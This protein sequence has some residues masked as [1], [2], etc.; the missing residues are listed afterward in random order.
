MITITNPKKFTIIIVIIVLVLSAGIFRYVWGS[1]VMLKAGDV[2]I[3]QGES[4]SQIWRALVSDGF[5][6]RTIPW[7]WYARSGSAQKIQAGK[8]H[9]E[10]GERI[11]DVVNRFVEGD[12]N[13]NE[14]SITFPEGFT[15]TQI[16]QRLEQ[17]GIGTANGFEQEAVVGN[18]SDKF[19]FLTGL[20]AKR[21]LEG[22]LFP[23]TYRI[24]KDDTSH[25]VIMKMLGN[26][27]KK[28]SQE[29][30][31]SAK[32]QHRTLDQE[33]TIASIIEKEVFH[34]E[35]LPTVAGIFWKR[36]DESLGLYADSTI[37]YAL[38]KGDELTVTDLATDSPYNTRKY[39][40]LPPTA[41]GNPGLVAITAALNPVK[42]DYYYYLTTP[43][44]TTVYAKTNDQHN[45]N[46]QKY[47]K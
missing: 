26:F 30:R 29:M 22:Y 7:K 21:S 17:K 27:D 47:L 12:V 33:I 15:I 18:Y 14:V 24:A 35:D 40:D 39:K 44:R 2:E 36:L 10:K 11:K 41:I 4:A 25:D 28:V 19:S 43:D 38:Q 32:A 23:D 20:S 3:S 9:V 13:Q 46:K 8:Y 45:V 5:A 37:R 16:G 34:A 1:G 31:D 6:D 42:S